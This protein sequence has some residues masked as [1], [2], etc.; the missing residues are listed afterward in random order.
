MIV[1]EF[2]ANALYMAMVLLAALVVWPTDRLPS[3]RDLVLTVLGTAVGLLLAHWLAF[4]LAAHVTTTGGRWAG[5]AAQEAL[6]GFAGGMCVALLACLPF[7]LLEGQIAHRVTLFVLAVLPAVIGGAIAR[8][9]GRAFLRTLV[10]AGVVLAIALLVV[11][12]KA[13]LNH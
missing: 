7:L 1:R 6:A 5:A 12:V 11:E 4:R 10:S 2:L 9:R 3:D 13:A 8:L